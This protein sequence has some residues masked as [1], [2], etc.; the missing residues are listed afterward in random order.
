MIQAGVGLSK[1]TE[2]HREAGKEAACLPAVAG[3]KAETTEPFRV[4]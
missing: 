3:A 1:K 4:R 2:D